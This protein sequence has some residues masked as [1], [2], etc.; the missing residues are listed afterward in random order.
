MDG[1]HILKACELLKRKCLENLKQLKVPQGVW[2]RSK[3]HTIRSQKEGGGGSAAK[4]TASSWLAPGSAPEFSML[5]LVPQVSRKPSRF[6]WQAL[7][8]LPCSCQLPYFSHWKHPVQFYP[9][10][11]GA[12][13][14]LGSGQA[15]ESRGTFP[16][17]V[18][19]PGAGE[20]LAAWHSQAGN[21]FF[22]C[23]YESFMFSS[24]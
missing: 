17:K 11:S 22:L 16:V 18:W 6:D 15:A 5:G 12:N 20:S 8:P 7:C 3:N 2:G 9:I 21:P 10:P 13:N 24:T 23:F 1:L 14:A 4:P 19:A